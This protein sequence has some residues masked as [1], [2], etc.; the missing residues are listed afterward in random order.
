[1]PALLIPLVKSGLEFHDF[2]IVTD[3][4]ECQV[5]SHLPLQKYS[6][7]LFSFSLSQVSY[8]SMQLGLQIYSNCEDRFQSCDDFWTETLPCSEAF[9][10]GLDFYGRSI[11]MRKVF[12]VAHSFKHGHLVS[13]LQLTDIVPSELKRQILYVTV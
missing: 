11:D 13:K 8:P 2:Q 10:N 12:L 1:M 6:S 3:L 7:K 5:A 9:E 4:L